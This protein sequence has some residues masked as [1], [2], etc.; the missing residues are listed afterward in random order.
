MEVFAGCESDCQS[1]SGA[2]LGLAASADDGVAAAFSLVERPLRI[3]RPNFRSDESAPP[4]FLPLAPDGA[5]MC[6]HF[7]S[8]GGVNAC[9]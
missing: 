5:F 6:Q 2:R 9:V 8:W 3:E 1:R 4:F 7:G